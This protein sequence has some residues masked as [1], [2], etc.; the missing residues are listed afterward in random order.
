MRRVHLAIHPIQVE[1]VAWVSGL[2]DLL[3]RPASLIA[4][5]QYLRFADRCAR[6]RAPVYPLGDL[7]DFSDSRPCWPNPPP[8]RFPGGDRARS[9]D[10][11]PSLEIDHRLGRM[12]APRHDSLHHH[13]KGTAQSAGRR[14]PPT[15]LQRPAESPAIPFVFYLIKLVWP[16]NLGIDYG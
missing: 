12:A 13:R 14:L 2:K 4:L 9:L 1:A 16:M 11:S 6:G 5:W 10:R 8:R 15:L 3:K 7:P